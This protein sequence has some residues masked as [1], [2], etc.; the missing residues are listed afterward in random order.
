MQIFVR[1]P[2][3]STI[4]LEVENSYSIENVEA[5]IQ[6]KTGDPP[7][8]QQLTFANQVLQPGRTLSDYNIQKES[9]LFL[10]LAT[11]GG[12]DAAAVPTLSPLGW[13]L[14]AAGI[15]ALTLMRRRDRLAAARD[16]G[17]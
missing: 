11:L 7:S 10:T 14:T 15:C 9:T 8:Q 4:T 1:T 2:T 17:S 3:G 5:K 16:T 12:Q 13:A 6:D